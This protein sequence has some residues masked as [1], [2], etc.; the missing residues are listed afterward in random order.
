MRP[1]KFRG[2]ALACGQWAYGSLIQRSGRAFIFEE[3]V[4]LPIEKIGQMLTE[5]DPYSIHQYTGRTGKNKVKIFG[6]DFIK[7]VSGS[8]YLVE[9]S[10]GYCGYRIYESNSGSSTMLN[11]HHTIHYEVI[12]NAFENPE[13]LEGET[14]E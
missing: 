4:Y 2:K 3:G 13:L 10:D 11:P 12:G 5:V 6:Q 7:T 9:W 1:I 14:C 8:I